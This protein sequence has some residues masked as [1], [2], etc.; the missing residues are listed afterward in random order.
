MPA[1]V[2]KKNLIRRLDP[3]TPPLTPMM[4]HIGTSIGSQIT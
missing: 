3:V 1:I 4:M 2:Y